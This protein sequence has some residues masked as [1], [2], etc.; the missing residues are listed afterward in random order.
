MFPFF[1]SGFPGPNQRSART[2]NSV[3]FLPQQL[4]SPAPNRNNDVSE[5]IQRAMF[6]GLL[7]DLGM[8]VMNDNQEDEET[9]QFPVKDGLMQ[10]RDAL[11][12]ILEGI[13]ELQESCNFLTKRI[14]D[15]PPSIRNNTYSYGTA[16][17]LCTKLK[18]ALK[19]CF[20]EESVLARV[21]SKIAKDDPNPPS[22]EDWVEAW[23]KEK[24]FRIEEAG[25]GEAC[26]YCT[27]NTP[28][29]KLCVCSCKEGGCGKCVLTHYYNATDQGTKT[30]APCPTCRAEFNVS[31]IVSS[32]DAYISS[33]LSKYCKGKSKK[34][35]GKCKKCEKTADACY[36]CG[37]GTSNIEMCA[38][39]LISD[40]WDKEINAS[41]EKTYC[42]DCKKKVKGFAV[43]R[44]HVFPSPKKRKVIEP[45]ENNKRRK[46]NK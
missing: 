35:H 26:L 29:T 31:D 24:K 40:V 28:N 36:D 12:K 16:V 8:G 20:E 4:S 5:S 3:V 1:S 17:A 46:I 10:A 33:V 6:L 22:V 2:S 39:C 37:C 42:K 14:G 27:E 32:K 41:Q 21:L 19:T 25:E 9:L 23:L 34:S 43:F 30:S 44:Q 38:E 13:E 11:A 15:L 7:R 18:D 45:K